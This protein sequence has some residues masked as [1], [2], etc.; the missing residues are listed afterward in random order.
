MQ[1]VR[2]WCLAGAT[3]LWWMGALPD[4]A[5]GG[6]GATGGALEITQLLNHVELAAQLEQQIEMVYNQL[7]QIQNMVQNTEKITDFTFGDLRGQ[8][9]QLH[10]V[11]T[12]GQSLA[13]TMANV[14]QIFREKFPGTVM[15]P[16]AISAF[17]PGTAPDNPTYYDLYRVW[18]QSNLDTIEGTLAANNLG[19]EQFVEEWDLID[20]L[21]V[22]SQSATGRMQA[23]DVSNLIASQ[24]VSQLQKLRQVMT[25]Q[26]QMQGTAL[27]AE[28]QEKSVTKQILQNGV[29]DFP[30][31]TNDG[32]AI[33]LLK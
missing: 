21:N 22:L 1:R 25:S 30:F 24:T 15:D 14:D 18:S 26:V 5:A 33:Q 8:I 23:L 29:K 13:Y 6:G 27:A 7:Q 4:A 12:R 31:P 20:K 32:S 17:F 19:A 2:A 3:A 16:R 10:S 28:Q 11:L 9:L